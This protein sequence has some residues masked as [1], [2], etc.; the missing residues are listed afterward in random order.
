MR[1]W[2]AGPAPR[3]PLPDAQREPDVPNGLD[4]LRAALRLLLADPDADVVAAH[5]LG[6]PSD[7]EALRRVARALGPRYTVARLTRSARQRDEVG[8]EAPPLGPQTRAPA[9]A[10][11]ALAL[12]VGLGT[13]AALLADVLQVDPEQVG[14]LLDQARR[15]AYPALAPSCPE[16]AGTV[17]RYADDTLDNVDAA[18]LVRHARGCAR[19]RAAIESR[20]W[21]D[22]D[23]RARVDELQ[24]A[25]PPGPLEPVSGLSR[26]TI[27]MA[28]AVG[29]VVL[30]VVLA[31]AGSLAA[32]CSNAG[33][34]VAARGVEPIASVTARRGP[35][36]QISV[37]TAGLLAVVEVQ[38]Q[39]THGAE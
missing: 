14:L 35:S 1:D 19:C 26:A 9:R 31:I 2:G 37:D 23:L 5:A 33:D 4:R 10:A 28:R 25:L 29:V 7:L 13:G 16:Y 34:S 20:W 3:M 8:P 36:W 38:G 17:G 6:A 39:A 12:Q 32:R 15:A 11:L 24:R 21:I 27:P 18:K 22:E 30:V